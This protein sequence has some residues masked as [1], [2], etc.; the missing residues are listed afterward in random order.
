MNILFVCT[1]NICRSPLAEGILRGKFLRYNI[2]G[3]VDSCGFETFHL[4]DPPDH[5]A[6]KIAK[7]NGIDISGHR[8]RIFHEGDFD[9]FD[10][11]YVMDSYHF[12]SVMR[13][14]R[15]QNDRNKVDYI[16]N[17]VEPGRKI[18]VNDPYF[19]HESAFET[20]FHQLDQA[21][22]VIAKSLVPY[23]FK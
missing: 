4:G 20:V 7:Q 12:D 17:S 3:A 2:K 5:R 1:G 13:V 15:N 18:P 19:E 8:V 14:A 22:D 9:R 10:R 6:Q 11:I 21:C 16:M 23:S